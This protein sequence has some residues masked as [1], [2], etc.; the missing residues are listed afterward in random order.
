MK[1]SKQKSS[2]IPKGFDRNSYETP[3]YVFEALD[4]EFNF[5]WDLCATKETAKCKD[6]FSKKD[7]A[8][9]QD[10]FLLDGWLW[11]NPPYSPL[12]PWLQRIQEQA[13]LGAN[14]V[15]LVPPIVTTAYFAKFLPHE[16]RFVIGRISFLANKQEIT[17]NR[18]A[19]CFLIFRGFKSSSS[20][21]VTWIH[22]QDLELGGK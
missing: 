14:I 22:R 17:G 16:V 4:R 13:A 9:K 10:W 11:I 7:D 2:N 15:A 6:Y 1:K 3:D 19:S 12:K 18:D 8:F 21:K 20:P 5:T